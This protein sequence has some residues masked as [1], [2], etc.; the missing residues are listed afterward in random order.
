M[1]AGVREVRGWQVLAAGAPPRFLTNVGVPAEDNR[2]MAGFTPAILI[3][4]K[5]SKSPTNLGVFEVV[6]SRKHTSTHTSRVAESRTVRIRRE[7]E[8][9]LDLLQSSLHPFLVGQ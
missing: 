9:D 6:L 8:T 3:S 4:G 1:V 7:P 2:K 5:R